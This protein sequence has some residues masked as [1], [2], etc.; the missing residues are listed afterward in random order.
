MKTIAKIILLSLIISFLYAC[1]YK[2]NKQIV[3]DKNDTL[4]ISEKSKNIREYVEKNV[5]ISH[6]GST[7]FTPEQS[8][9]SYRWARNM[10]TNYLE[11]DIQMTKDSVL[12]LY[13]DKNLLRTTNIKNVF[14]ERSKNGISD[15]SLKELRQLDIGSWFNEKYPNR[16]RKNFKNLKILN[17]KDITK[18]AE[19][20]RIKKINNQPVK[21]IVN[22]EWTGEYLYEKDPADNGN[23]PGLY[24]ETKNPKKGLEKLLAK[25]LTE[26]GWNITNNPKT[27]KTYPGKV[28]TA[29]TNARVILLSFS[30]ESLKRLEQN[31]AGIPKLL[32]LW[33]P[34]MK[35]DIKTEYKNAI[36]FA[37]QNNVQIIGGSIAGEPNNYGELNAKWM[38][39]I[40]HNAGLLIHPY[41]FDTEKQIEKYLDRI[42]GINTNR[43]DLAL[44]YYK[45][46]KIKNPEKVLTE[47]GY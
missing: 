46:K 22:G 2:I 3:T 43:T 24:L 35:G 1:N 27:I 33:R 5:I 37:V 4:K 29:N 38:T 18:I 45:P 15:F 13:H 36:K 14:P 30:K 34:S 9:A 32:L 7:Y 44:K 40:A 26:Y 47:L 21:E 11:F 19:G 25:K 41:T 17:L 16:F 42:D 31:L 10:G 39:D 6:R 8:E 23:R 20:Y 12:V 28:A